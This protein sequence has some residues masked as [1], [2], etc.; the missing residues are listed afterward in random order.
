MKIF[1]RHEIEI[2]AGEAEV[3]KLIDTLSSANDLLWPHFRW[4]RMRFNKPLQVGARGGHGPIGYWIEEY[5]PNK[6]IIFRFDNTHWLSRG[7]EGYH[8]LFIKRGE[9]GTT[10]VHE[11]V[12]TIRG[13]ALLLWP[14]VVRPLH[15]SLVEDALARVAQHFDSTYPFPPE[16]PLWV[17]FLGFLAGAKTPGMGVS[18]EAPLTR[19]K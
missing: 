18:Q 15:D 3:G 8:T 13:R 6:H 1:N 10:L 7:I 9:S 14:L 17:R 4:P 19:L 12:G 16:L 5:E 2:A 11:I